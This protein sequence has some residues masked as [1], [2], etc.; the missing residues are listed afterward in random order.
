[1]AP[2]KL[3]HEKKHKNKTPL[4]RGTA[5]LLFLFLSNEKA[6]RHST[7]GLLRAAVSYLQCACVCVRGAC[8]HV[9]T[10]FSLI[11]CSV[12]VTMCMCACLV[13][14]CMYTRASVCLPAR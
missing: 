12:M 4:I 3:S 5:A 1:M 7:R 13:R 9:Y 2:F 10:R 6:T 11:T 8:V 14:V